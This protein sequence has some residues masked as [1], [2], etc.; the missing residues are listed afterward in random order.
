MD[1]VISISSILCNTQFLVHEDL[2]RKKVDQGA[3]SLHE[4]D[5]CKQMCLGGQD[6]VL[7]SPRDLHHYTWWNHLDGPDL[8]IR[9]CKWAVELWQTAHLLDYVR[10]AIFKAAGDTILTTTLGNSL[11]LSLSHIT[12]RCKPIC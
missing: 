9:R 12:L 8:L 4:Y 1:L 5:S 11:S 10:L 6:P 7:Q 3:M 2:S